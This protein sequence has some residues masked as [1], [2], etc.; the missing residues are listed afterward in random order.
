MSCFK[1]ADTSQIRRSKA[2]MSPLV[3]ENLHV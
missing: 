2:E 1:F 3:L